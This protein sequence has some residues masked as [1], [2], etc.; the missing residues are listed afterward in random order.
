MGLTVLCFPFLLWR[1]LDDSS[2]SRWSRRF[3][4]PPVLHRF[5]VDCDAAVQRAI[6]AGATP[7][8]P[9]QDMFWGDRYGMVVDPFGHKWSIATHL[10][11]L[12]PEEMQRGME[13]AFSQ[14]PA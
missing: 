5:V 8:M 13:E 6:D 12:T 7:L 4:P 2:D 11:D 1:L 9:V 10:K 14:A 3:D